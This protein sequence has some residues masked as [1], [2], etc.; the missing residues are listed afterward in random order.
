VRE[1][2]R[3]G[4]DTGG[5]ELEL[6]KIVVG[7][8]FSADGELALSYASSLAQELQADLF[9]LHVVE[10]PAYQDLTPS[11]RAL[12]EDLR[13]AVRSAVEGRLAALVDGEAR[14][15]AR[16]ST[17]MAS[18]KPSAEIV[19]YAENE[20]ADLIVV[21]SSGMGPIGRLL[22]GSTAEAVVRHATVPVLVV[23]EPSQRKGE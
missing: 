3:A 5:D 4:R 2:A 7:C 20:G 11:T 10:P 16:V 8:D 19:K 13:S 22:V 9:L 23:R 1:A 15:W 14:S 17:A 18:G 21:G 6:E 12:A